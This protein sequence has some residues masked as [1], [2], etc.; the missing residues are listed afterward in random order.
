[1]LVYVFFPDY[2]QLSAFG[3]CYSWA[4]SIFDLIC[5]CS[6]M[7]QCWIHSSS[8]GFLLL[9]GDSVPSLMKQGSC[10]WSATGNGVFQIF[11]TGPIFASWRYQT[12][13]WFY[14]VLIKLLH[15]IGLMFSS[16]N[17]L[18]EVHHCWLL[19]SL[20]LFS[21]PLPAEGELKMTEN[22]THKLCMLLYFHFFSTCL[23]SGR[24]FFCL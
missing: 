24:C 4:T 23:Q 16:F 12:Y 20:Y 22:C 15:H 7:L 18:N 11:R 9:S 13:V 14:S 10:W 5:R 6:Y 3:H 17:K 1:M 8:S 21:I 19:C 2:S